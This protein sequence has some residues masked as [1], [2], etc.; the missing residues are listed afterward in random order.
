MDR[1]Q[2]KSNRKISEVPDKFS[3]YLR[4]EINFQQ[5]LIGILGA[6][7]VGKT[8]LLL[9]IGKT[10]SRNEVLYTALD[11]LFFTENSLYDLA[12]K[13]HQV[14]GELFL[15]DE[16]HKY[17]SWAREI[18]LIYDDFPDLQVIFTSSSILDIYRAESDLSRRVSKYILPELS[19][20]EYLEFYHGFYHPGITLTEIT[21]NHEDISYKVLKR[22]KPLKH[23][24]EYLVYGNYPFFEGDVDDYHQKIRNTTNL[25]LEIDLP[26]VQNIDHESI[27]KLKRL[28]YV[29]STNVPFTP[30][31]SKLSEKVG[32]HRNNLV[33]ALQLLSKAQL[34][35]LLYK[36]NKSISILNKPDKI[37]L[38]N[39][40]LSYAIS[41]NLPDKGN[42]RESYFIA[43]IN[44]YHSIALPQSGDFLVDNSFLFEI[45]GKT[46]TSKQ[47]SHQ[48]KAYVVKDDIETGA[49]KNIPLWLF[50]FLY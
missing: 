27:A 41:D 8:T 3:R 5:R 21:E 16:V 39:P 47:I 30:N 25:I 43:H 9:Q 2:I 17:P 38:H 40:N 20:R 28:L 10:R 35:R 37:W 23:F 11:D 14:G 13:F 6:R 42:L 7:G 1:L 34:I 31:I 32:L 29:L 46:K 49:G 19:F 4:K 33:Q 26:T 22:I 36:K 44:V 24:S 48:S 45:G 12:E 18:K 15:L 50:G